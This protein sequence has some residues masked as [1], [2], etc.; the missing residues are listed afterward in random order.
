M[1]VRTG[2]DAAQG[3]GH[4]SRCRGHGRVLLTGLLLVVCSACF[5]NYWAISPADTPPPVCF[6]IEPRTTN[7]GMAPPTLGWVLPYQSIVKELPYR[8]SYSLIW[9]K[10]FLHWGPLL[11]GNSRLCQVDIK[12]TR[13]NLEKKKNQEKRGVRNVPPFPS[14]AWVDATWQGL[15]R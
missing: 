8:P 1:E 7:P 15:R 6:L 5:L 13:K 4:R 9:W 3:P 11:S 12:L 10:C 14:L 2:T